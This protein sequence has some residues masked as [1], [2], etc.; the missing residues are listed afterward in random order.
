MLE[1][2]STSFD[3]EVMVSCRLSD[4]VASRKVKGLSFDSFYF[5]VAAFY[6]NWTIS[7]D[8]FGRALVFAF[9]N[10]WVLLP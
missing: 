7:W 6:S 3:V 10:D 8:R 2:A 1:R 9:V 5:F 4:C